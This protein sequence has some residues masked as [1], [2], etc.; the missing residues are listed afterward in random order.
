MSWF[1]FKTYHCLDKTLAVEIAFQADVSEG[2]V[3]FVALW[4]FTCPLNFHLPNKN[5][6]LVFVY[7]SAE[8]LPQAGKC[9]LSKSGF[10]L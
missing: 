6:Y 1:Y 4:L 9:F 7:L 8:C 5:E 10:F 2:M 3:W